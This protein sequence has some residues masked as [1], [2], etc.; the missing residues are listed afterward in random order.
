MPLLHTE[1]LEIQRWNAAQPVLACVELK[2]SRSLQL[3]SH[4]QGAN[5]H[6]QGHLKVLERFGR[7]PKRNAALGRESTPEELAYM[8]SDEAQGRPY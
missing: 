5:E 1:K 6:V 8:A 7:F 4:A 3:A 2:G